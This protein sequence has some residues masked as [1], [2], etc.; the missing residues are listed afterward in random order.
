MLLCETQEF[1]IIDA[2]DKG[3]VKQRAHRCTDNLAAVYICTAAQKYH[4]RCARCIRRAQNHADV[5]GILHAIESQIKRCFLRC[6]YEIGQCLAGRALQQQQ[7]SLRRVR[8]RAGGKEPRRDTAN[9]H[10]AQ[11]QLLCQHG[12]PLRRQGT[13]RHYGV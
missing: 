10:A 7:D 11:T 13:L 3:N 5:A 6:V 1:L 4:A 8:L 12:S 9:R 2:A